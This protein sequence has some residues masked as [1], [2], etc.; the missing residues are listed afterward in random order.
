[1]TSYIY[2]FFGI[3]WSMLFFYVW[4]MW[5]FLL[6]RIFADIFR[7]DD[8]S[9]WAKALWLIF[10]VVL[11]FLGVLI[12]VITRNDS[13]VAHAGSRP[14]HRGGGYDD[15]SHDA[16]SYGDYS[17]G[18]RPR[19]AATATSAGSVAGQLAQLAQLKANGVLTDAEFEAQ[20]ARLLA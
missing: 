17:Y 2:P 8:L 16:Y 19:G 20:K 1:M 18:D 3:F 10:V 12:Y 4:M 11:P 7:S 9:G 5:L 14:G 6:F 15:Y 13:M